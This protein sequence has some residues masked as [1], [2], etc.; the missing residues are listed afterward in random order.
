M[1]VFLLVGLSV[2]LCVRSDEFDDAILSYMDDQYILGAGVAYY[3]GV[4]VF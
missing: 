3:N 2:L 4:S 1:S